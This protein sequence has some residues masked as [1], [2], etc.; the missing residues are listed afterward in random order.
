MIL[1]YFKTKIQFDGLRTK[2]DKRRDATRWT[3]TETE[4]RYELRSVGREEAVGAAHVSRLYYRDFG[5]GLSEVGR[6]VTRSDKPSSVLLRW[7]LQQLRAGT[8]SLRFDLHDCAGVTG[9][10]YPFPG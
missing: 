10:Y 6:S 1:C 3:R 4:K 8:L 7:R 9:A 5:L 2:I